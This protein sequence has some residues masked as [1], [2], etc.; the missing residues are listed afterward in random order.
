VG[1]VFV[2]CVC[3]YLI[4]ILIC[5]CAGG[6]VFFWMFRKSCICNAKVQL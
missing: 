4:R 5:L 1:S 6:F 3:G 2:L